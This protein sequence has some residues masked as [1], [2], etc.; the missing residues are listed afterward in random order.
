MN[1]PEKR[2][3]SALSGVGAK[4]KVPSSR[5]TI[6]ERIDRLERELT[7]H[8][9]WG[10]CPMD[11]E[12]DCCDSIVV[13]LTLLRSY[14]A[15]VTMYGEQCDR[16][17]EA[18]ERHQLGLGGEHVETLVIE[19]LDNWGEEIIRRIVVAGS[20]SAPTTQEGK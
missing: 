9:E 15:V 2:A 20:P 16:L 11:G 4:I 5:T 1:A 14:L 10:E 18:C 6:A 7:P 8:F 13:E 3:P 12:Q 17:R 19:A